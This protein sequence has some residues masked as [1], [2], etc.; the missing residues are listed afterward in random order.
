MIIWIT[1]EKPHPYMWVIGWGQGGG[2]EGCCL[3]YVAD[4]LVSPSPL[5]SLKSQTWPQSQDSKLGQGSGAAAREVLTRRRPLEKPIQKDTHMLKCKFVI[6]CSEV[7]DKNIKP[8]RI[9]DIKFYK[10]AFSSD[11]TFSSHCLLQSPQMK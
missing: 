1:Q 9:K 11:V 10:K 2:G 3:S 5:V 8:V 6:P 4:C 7:Q